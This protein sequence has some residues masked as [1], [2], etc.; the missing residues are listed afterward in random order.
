VTFGALANSGI[1]HIKATHYG[2]RCCRAF[3]LKNMPAGWRIIDKLFSRQRACLH[4]CDVARSVYSNGN[5]RRA[6]NKQYT[7]TDATPAI[8]YAA[9]AA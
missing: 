2:L 3:P 8:A 6:N 9:L 5:A 4:F 1:C 7:I